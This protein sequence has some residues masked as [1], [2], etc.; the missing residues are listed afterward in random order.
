MLLCAACNRALSFFFDSTGLHR[1]PFFFMNA[2]HCKLACK[3]SHLTVAFGNLIFKKGVNV[4]SRGRILCQT[5]PASLKR[6]LEQVDLPSEGTSASKTTQ[7][8][9]SSSARAML[10][11]ALKLLRRVEN[12]NYPQ[13]HYSLS[14]TDY[15][16]SIDVSN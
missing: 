2:K 6:S 3:L 1:S 4:V 14:L 16:P 7:E 12:F 11:L 8:Q 13:L 10:T 5:M 15:H 9:A